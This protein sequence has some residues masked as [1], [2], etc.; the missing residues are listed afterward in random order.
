MEIFPLEFVYN[1]GVELVNILYKLFQILLIYIRKSILSS[2]EIL[3][4]AFV[5][6][7]PVTSVTI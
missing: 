3:V 6:V 4:K 5:N 7:V 1:E 2:E